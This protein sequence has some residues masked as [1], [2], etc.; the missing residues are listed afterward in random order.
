MV[1]KPTIKQAKINRK[2]YLVQN[3]L[4]HQ[5]QRKG[6]EVYI[7]PK[8]Y[9]HKL[10]NFFKETNSPIKTELNSSVNDEISIKMIKKEM[11]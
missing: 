11:K 8:E 2:R 10:Q 3:L 9:K 1:S 7:D 5:L 4:Y 6:K